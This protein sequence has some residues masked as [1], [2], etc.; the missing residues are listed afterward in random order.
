MRRFTRLSFSSRPSFFRILPVSYLS[1]FSEPQSEPLLVFQSAG[2]RPMAVW[3]FLSFSFLPFTRSVSCCGTGSIVF[4]NVNV[5]V[6][7][8][9]RTAW[10]LAFL[11]CVLN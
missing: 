4:V 5:P 10:P 1:H 6:L 11:L 3:L 7:T 2:I 8:N 9:P